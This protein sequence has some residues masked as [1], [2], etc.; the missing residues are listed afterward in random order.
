MSVPFTKIVYVTAYEFRSGNPENTIYV[1]YCTQLIQ[2]SA[3]DIEQVKVML[4]T[5]EVIQF[6]VK[7]YEKDV[8][9]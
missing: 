1:F 9:T 6:F 5:G 3:G 4:S 8:P 2:G 7:L